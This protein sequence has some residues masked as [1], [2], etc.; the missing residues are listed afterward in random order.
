MRNDLYSNETES[1]EKPINNEFASNKVVKRDFFLILV[2]LFGNIVIPIIFSLISFAIFKSDSF[3]KWGSQVSSLIG[4]SL[5]PITFYFMHRK[6]IIPIAVQRFKQ[7]KHY[8]GLIAITM[9]T[10][11]LL[12]I[13]YSMF[14]ELLPQQW[15][16]DDTENEKA[17]MKLFKEQWTWPL[18]FLNIVIVAPFA[19]ELIFRHLL[20]HELGKKLTY[21]VMYVVSILMFA[22]IHVIGATS[23]FEIGPYLIMATG[24]I[25]AYHISGRNLAMTITLH[26]LNNFISFVL[27]IFTLI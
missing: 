24:F 3:L 2:Y 5:V 25:I 11:Y 26:M 16:F 4:L 23:P 22:G 7:L 12:N 9:I 10:M 20:I 15:Q 18:L 17:I 14:I 13:A 6:N 8:I 27:T 21:G 19:E 1:Q